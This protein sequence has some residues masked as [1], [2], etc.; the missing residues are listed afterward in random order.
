MS[1]LLAP[2]RARFRARAADEA[3]R[4][5]PLWEA[6]PASPEL[7][8]MVH[9]LAGAAGM[10]G[11]REL[12]DV[13]RAADEHLADGGRLDAAQIDR[14]EQMLQEAATATD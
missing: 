3:V 8:A 12:G 9:G 6:D 11:H 14:L 2:L 13:A 4:L 7:R 5:R 1:D 10:F